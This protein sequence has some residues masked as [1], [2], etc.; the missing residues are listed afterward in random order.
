VLST[1]ENEDVEACFPRR[2]R[3]T[4]Q[5]DDVTSWSKDLTVEIGGRDVINH[6]GAAALGVIADRS[7]LTAGL[8][9]ALA[10]PGFVPVHDRGWVFA[11]TAVLIADGGRVMSDVARCGTN[12]GSTAWWPGT[13]RYGAP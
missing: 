11:D 9:R 12:S 3:S 6:A 10:R 5:V 1:W 8:S 7:G 13:R 4:F 2:S